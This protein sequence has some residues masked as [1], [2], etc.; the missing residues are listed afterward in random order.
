FAHPVGRQVVFNFKG[1]KLT[2]RA[3]TPEVG[4]NE[5]DVDCDYN[6]GD[7]RIGFN[8]S[9]ILD[10]VRRLGSEKVIFELSTPVSPGVLRP[11]EEDPDIQK[12][13][14]LMPIRLD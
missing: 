7:L 13:Y 4:W 9:F 5:E 8:V 3:E 2:L 10:V 6:G 14:L 1:R 11:A 12:V